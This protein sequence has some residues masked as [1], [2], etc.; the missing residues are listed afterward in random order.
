[1][2]ASSTVF[3]SVLIIA[4]TTII[5]RSREGTAAGHVVETIIFGFLLLIAL[6]ILAIV[7]PTFAKALGYL[8]IVGAFVVN[9]PAVFSFLGDFGRGRS[10]L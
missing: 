6:L 8:G 1:V 2:N 4:A 5:R 10:L 3:A 9:G 7:L